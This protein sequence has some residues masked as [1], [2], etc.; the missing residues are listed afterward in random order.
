MLMAEEATELMEEAGSRA[1]SGRNRIF[2][3]PV[4]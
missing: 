4:S 2:Y 3:K 1:S